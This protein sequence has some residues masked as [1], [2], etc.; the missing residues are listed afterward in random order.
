MR[1]SKTRRPREKLTIEMSVE[2]K[3]RVVAAAEEKGQTLVVWVG[4]ACEAELAR[5]E[6][7]RPGVIGA[8]TENLS[9]AGLNARAT[10]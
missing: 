7:A 2:M 8:G 10:A 4:R 9:A 5:S 3:A 1:T 6:G